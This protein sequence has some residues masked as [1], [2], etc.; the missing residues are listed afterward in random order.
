MGLKAGIY[1]D[2]GR[3]SCSQAWNDGAGNLPEGTVAERE[4]GLYGH[5]DQDIALYFGAWNFDTIKVDG[6]G[7]A[8]YWASR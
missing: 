4:V 6:C 5:V 1:S 8:H 7:I 3:N 2:V